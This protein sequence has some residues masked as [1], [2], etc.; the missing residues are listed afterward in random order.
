[1]TFSDATNES[2][3]EDMENYLSSKG[4]TLDQIKNALQEE[5]KY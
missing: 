3:K 2:M 1:M 4:L 5:F